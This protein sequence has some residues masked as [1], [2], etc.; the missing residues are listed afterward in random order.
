VAYKNLQLRRDTAAIWTNNNPTLLIG[1]IGYE[2]DTNKI[3]IGDGSTAW[4]SLSYL[5]GVSGVDTSGTPEANDYARFTD[6]DTIEGRNYSE[7]KTDLSLNLVENT[8][9]STWAGSTNITTLGT[10]ATV[11]NITIANGGTIGQAAGPLLTFDDTNDYLE[12]SGCNVGIGTTAPN[13]K[14]SFGIHLLPSSISDGVARTD[15]SILLYELNANNW[16]G[17]GTD[18]F[19]NF[20]MKTGTG[21]TYRYLTMIA[22]SGNV[23]IG[24]TSPVSILT[25]EGSLTLKEQAAA[26]ADTAAYGQIW[27][28]NTTPCQLWFTD[29]AGTDLRIAPQNLQTTATP[30]FSGLAITNNV[31]V[32]GN[33]GIGTVSPSAKLSV[34]GG[35]YVGGDINP[36]DNNIY[37]VNDCSARTF[38]DRTPFYAGNALAEIKKIKGKNGK[39]DHSTLPEFA[40]SRIKL[41]HKD[42]NDPNTIIE[43]VEEGRNLGSMVS[44]LTIAVQQLTERIEV[45]ESKK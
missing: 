27:V 18:G 45:L 35:V 10:I 16:A 14:L 39:I 11:G 6:V 36:G 25:L 37:V 20:W 43:S 22:A 8:A 32:G 3:K 28:K 17:M 2:T 19:G 41:K 21:A 31:T 15:A 40:R 1:E 13:A 29:D 24:T 5:S 34:V 44:I 30:T 12:I 4:D 9:L 33:V 38:T 7:V 26:G 42:P 23:G